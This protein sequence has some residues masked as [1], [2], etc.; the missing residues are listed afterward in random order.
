MHLLNNYYNC[1]DD[2]ICIFINGPSETLIEG[3]YAEEGLSNVFLPREQENMFYV[4]RY[5]VGFGNYDHASNTNRKIEMPYSYYLMESS[6]VPAILSEERGVGAT[7]STEN[8]NLPKDQNVITYIIG[9]NETFAAGTTITHPNISL[10]FSEEGGADFNKSIEYMAD[11]IFTHYTP[12]NGVN[13]DKSGGTFYILRPKM[14]GS[15]TIGVKH[16]LKNPLYIQEDGVALPEYN[17]ITFDENHSDRYRI[18]FEAKG[19]STYKVYCTGSKLGFYGFIYEINDATDITNLQTDRQRFAPGIYSIDG[20]QFSAPR[21]G[22]YIIG[23]KKV[24]RK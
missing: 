9:K 6:G 17:G 23:G 15:I 8:F 18:T 20:Q 4:T 10:T 1:P 24:L 12:G 2:S 14:D 22:L 5:N 13:G 3:C 21:K 19:G 16:N 11:S 7:L